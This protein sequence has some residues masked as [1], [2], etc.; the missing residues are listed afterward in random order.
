MPR[1]DKEAQGKRD[2]YYRKAKECGFRARS[3]FKLLQIDEMFGVFNGVRRAVDLCAAPG[4]WSQVLSRELRRRAKEDAKDATS[5]A[6]TPRI[7]SVDLQEMAPIEG[8]H[9]LQ[10]DI[11]SRETAE[12]IIGFFEGELAELVICDGAPDVTGLHQ[13]DEYVQSQ[14]LLAALNISTH[15]LKP[16]GTFVAKIFLGECYELLASQLRVFFPRV[17]CHKPDSSRSTS[18]EHFVVCEGFRKLPGYTPKLFSAL[19]ETAKLRQE[20]KSTT[21]AILQPFLAAGILARSASVAVASAGGAV[22]YS[23]FLKP[24]ATAGGPADR[25]SVV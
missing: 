10:G 17:T 6:W 19:E 15:L 4:S 9:I 7:V 2:V 8:V 1:R 13:I 14:L 25:K 23:R 21:N 11:T 24:P 16:G 20:E 22:S 12:K 18:T 5:P 3:A